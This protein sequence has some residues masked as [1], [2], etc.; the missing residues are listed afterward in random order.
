MLI[1]SVRIEGN[2]Q[3]QNKIKIIKIELVYNEKK[4][5]NYLCKVKL[6][7]GYKRWETERGTL[8]YFHPTLSMGVTPPRR[9]HCR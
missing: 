9:R 7:P 3:L 6:L 2:F 5:V 8:R 1:L 4:S